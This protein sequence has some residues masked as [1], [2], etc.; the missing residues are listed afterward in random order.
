M[1]ESTQ[2][3][4]YEQL[5]KAALQEQARQRGVSVPADATRQQL[6]DALRQADQQGR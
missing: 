5:D 6:Q 3:D 4:P 2:S 1:T